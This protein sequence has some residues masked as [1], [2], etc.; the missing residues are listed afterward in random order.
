VI[1]RGITFL[2]ILSKEPLSY[3]PTVSNAPGYYI[4]TQNRAQGE[5]KRRKTNLGTPPHT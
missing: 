5:E 4:L 2:N 1:C 3:I